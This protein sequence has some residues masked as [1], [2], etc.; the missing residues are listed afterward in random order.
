MF[1]A[2]HGSIEEVLYKQAPALR[3]IPQGSGHM[4]LHT[5]ESF[6]A[7]VR[8]NWWLYTT[9]DMRPG[10]TSGNPGLDGL[11]VH[12]GHF[13]NDMN[14]NA[15]IVRRDGHAKVDLEFGLRNYQALRFF[16]DAGLPLRMWR[17]YHFDVT[18]LRRHIEIQVVSDHPSSAEDNRAGKDVE[19]ASLAYPLPKYGP[20]FGHI[21]M[22]LDNIVTIM[23]GFVV[24][25]LPISKRRRPSLR[26][27]R[28][29]G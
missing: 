1:R 17:R 11:H 9:G 6:Q 8:A 20:K 21:G 14:Y 12:F 15:H 27:E 29:R 22:R 23:G 5:V 16:R 19:H 25:Q 2:Y 7:P 4:R 26:P 13:D 24:R 18:W 28:G 10:G 3:L